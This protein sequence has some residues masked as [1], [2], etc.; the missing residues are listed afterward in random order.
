MDAGDALC[1][2]SFDDD[3]LA[4]RPTLED[5]VRAGIVYFDDIVES[6]RRWRRNLAAGRARYSD[7]KHALLLTAFDEWLERYPA[8]AARIRKVESTGLEVEGAGELRARRKRVS[9]ARRAVWAPL[10][11]PSSRRRTS[12]ELCAPGRRARA[13][14]SPPPEDALFSEVVRLPEARALL[15]G[16]CAWMSDD[17]KD[18]EGVDLEPLIQGA[19]I[20]CDT[21]FD[22]GRE[23]PTATLADLLSRWCLPYPEVEARVRELEAQGH[24]VE[25]A[26]RLRARHRCAEAAAREFLR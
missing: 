12:E 25:R 14:P 1:I 16:I 15:D 18:R 20:L 8:V 13:R 10:P 24:R 2:W 5:R 22:L 21:L 4:M 17:P 19:I 6:D 26:A 7:I 3:E 9:A 23:W 11:R